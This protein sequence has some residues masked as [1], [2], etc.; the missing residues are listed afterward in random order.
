MNGYEDDINSN[1]NEFD[2]LGNCME[3]IDYSQ[4]MTSGECATFYYIPPNP[5]GR[6]L[7]IPDIHGCSKTLRALIEKIELSKDDQLFLLGDYINKGP[8]EVGVIDCFLELMEQG[9]QLFP[10]RGNHE[11]VLISAHLEAKN[12]RGNTQELSCSG[13]NRVLADGHR[14]LPKYEP[15]FLSLPY[16]Y[17][18]DNHF[19]VHAGFN[20]KASNPFDDLET[21]LWI[22]DFE[23]DGTGLGEKTIIIG[24]VSAMLQFI[25]DDVKKHAPLITLDNGCV[26]KHKW[27]RGNLL[28]LNLNDWHLYIQPNID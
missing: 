12:R 10:L 3:A 5:N 20:L 26:Y 4:I 23:Y 9:Y 17:E 11:D 21:M 13:E 16:Y 8:D 27:F 2:R 28:C 19:L 14:I 1:Y 6:Q 15:F 25:E 22:P 24:H 18:L 7:A